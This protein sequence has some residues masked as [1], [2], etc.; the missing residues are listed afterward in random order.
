MFL[1]FNSF[2]QISEAKMHYI[3]VIDNTG[4]M[5]GRGS[6][7]PKNIWDAVKNKITETILSLD[8]EEESVISIYTFASSL[9]VRNINGLVNGS[10][11]T[12]M[13]INKSNKNIISQ[14]ISSISATGKQTCIYKAFSTLIDDL[15]TNNNEKLEK[16]NTR[17]FLFTDSEEQCNDESISC[18]NAFDKW[19]NIKSDQD[20]ASIIKLEESNAASSL[21]SCISDNSC[22][23]VI[24]EPI[25]Q[26]TKVIENDAVVK[27]NSS[28]LK[29]I[30]NFRRS[31]D[32]DPA[33]STMSTVKFQYN[34]SCLKFIDDSN[35]HLIEVD[36]LNHTIILEVTD[37]C[38]FAEGQVVEGYILYNKIIFENKFIKLILK[39]PNVRFSYTNDHIPGVEHDY[40]KINN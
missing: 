12:E 19:C 28:Q 24:K 17:I 29:Q 20:F 10:P 9:E 33:I 32:I 6:G 21:L 13:L 38:N 30:F 37:N 36:V 8:E 3:F 35:T 11:I 2:S 22:I 23:E 4:S 15:S 34:D 26:I 14:T 1:S 31:L 39:Y 40:R 25:T 5:E 7:S 18:S 27:F 16:Y